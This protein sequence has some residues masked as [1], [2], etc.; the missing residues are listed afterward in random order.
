MGI[1]RADGVGKRA[2]GQRNGVRHEG[3]RPAVGQRDE[4]EVVVDVEDGVRRCWLLLS[5]SSSS[6]SMLLD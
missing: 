5:S 2:G 4:I 3:E 1:E 6:S